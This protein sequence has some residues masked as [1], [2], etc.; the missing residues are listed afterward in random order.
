M[1]VGLV[2]ILGI[3]GFTFGKM[4]IEKDNV[5][6]ANESILNS[7]DEFTQKVTD[8]TIK[9]TD[10]LYEYIINNNTLATYKSVLGQDL[11]SNGESIYVD[12]ANWKLLNAWRD[13]YAKGEL[14]KM[15]ISGSA[16]Y[17]IDTPDDLFHLC[18]FD[19]S[20][21]DIETYGNITSPTLDETIIRRNNMNAIAGIMYLLEKNVPCILI[22]VELNKGLYKDLTWNPES[23]YSPCNAYGVMYPA[24][25]GRTTLFPSDYGDYSDYPYQPMQQS[26][27]TPDTSIDINSF[28]S[29]LEM[30]PFLSGTSGDTLGEYTSVQLSIKDEYIT[31]TYTLLGSGGIGISMPWKGELNTL[32]SWR[33]TCN[34]APFANLNT[35]WNRKI[36]RTYNQYGNFDDRDYIFVN[37]TDTNAITHSNLG[38]PDE[39]DPQYIIKFIKIQ[40][41]NA[42]VEDT[43]TFEVADV[44]ETAAIEGALDLITPGRYLLSDGTVGGDVCITTDPEK[45]QEL[46]DEVNKGTS[47]TDAINKVYGNSYAF[48][49]TETG[50]GIGNQESIS[51]IITNVTNSNPNIPQLTPTSAGVTSSGFVTMYN[52][53][54][55]SVRAF[56]STLWKKASDIS[57]IKLLFSDPM[58]AIISLHQIPFTPIRGSS[59]NVYV[60][61]YNTNVNMTTVTNQFNTMNMGTVYVKPKYN[62]FLDYYP[63]TNVEL[64][65]PFIGFVTLDV[66]IVMG[67]N[68]TLVYTFDVC[69]GSFVAN[70][71]SGKTGGVVATYPGSAIL[72]V[73]VTSNDYRELYSA[74]LNSFVGAVSSTSQE[75]LISSATA[76]LLDIVKSSQ[77]RI[78]RNGGF[79]GSNGFLSGYK[80]YLL[81][82]RPNSHHPSNYA[83]IMGNASNEL[84]TLGNLS[85]YTKVSECNLSCSGTAEE[86]R[87]ILDLL[88]EGVIL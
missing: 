1:G 38:S 73:P 45:L 37:G 67:A 8:G 34:G 3:L 78:Q 82:T 36:G 5:D 64:W 26:I 23:Y 10:E 65:L 80:P 17:T 43:F 19:G 12:Y 25:N 39:T 57:N 83:T 68:I 52:P 2:A 31:D 32:T 76:G 9:V 14:S 59:K 35:T 27:Y 55:T 30:T 21:K 49:N 66:N 47:L 11:G 56:A 24:R 71:I 58:S 54:S 13:S 41:K 77:P 7:W 16:T 74:T 72:S 75:N 18:G 42:T 4:V 48:V 79:S 51:Q 29:S 86:N 69:S 87:Q 63:Y 33:G 70:L 53:S 62:N 60:G 44:L 28:E 20:L 84:A 6:K 22:K 50:T 88:K 85:G 61:S 46:Q 15:S 81:I 40:S